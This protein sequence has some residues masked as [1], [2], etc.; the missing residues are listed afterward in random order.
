[1]VRPTRAELVDKGLNL[2]LSAVLL[3]STLSKT[4]DF[5]ADSALVNGDTSGH[6]ANNMDRRRGADLQQRANFGRRGLRLEELDEERNVGRNVVANG[7]KLLERA[8]LKS[9]GGDAQY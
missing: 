4:D 3:E 5:L 9:W 6:L 2:L 8:V 1:M 7:R